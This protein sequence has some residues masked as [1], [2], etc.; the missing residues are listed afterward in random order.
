MNAQRLLLSALMVL[1][2][3]SPD[4]PAATKQKEPA[5]PRDAI[6]TLPPYF[7]LKRLVAV[8]RFINKSGYQGQL[9]LGN[10]L[11]DMLTDALMRSGRFILVERQ[12]IQDVL[13][14]QDFAQSGRAIAAGAA[15]IGKLLNAQAIVIGTVT[16]YDEHVMVGTGAI[17]QGGT[18]FQVST[19]TARLHINVRVVD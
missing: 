19:A 12:Q 17:A 16:H 7:G 9:Q 14:E 11:A 4:L 1:A 3:P 5:R 2:L 13:R 18:Q 10:G 15:E 8:T 6:D